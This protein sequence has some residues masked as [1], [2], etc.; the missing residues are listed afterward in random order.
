MEK[1]NIGMMESQN[2]DLQ[3][4]TEDLTADSMEKIFTEEEL[5]HEFDYFVAQQMLEKL[6]SMGNISVDVFNKI[7]EKNRQTFSPYLSE[8]MPKMT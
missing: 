4:K 3:D 5:Q 8:I 6:L 1:Q 2:I 7:T